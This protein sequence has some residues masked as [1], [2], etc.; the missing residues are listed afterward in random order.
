[1][2]SPIIQS[3]HDGHLLMSKRDSTSSRRQRLAATALMMC[4]MSDFAK[5]LVIS[6]LRETHSG[7]SPMPN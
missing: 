4:E 7:A 1:M 5:A 2:I 3:G 6:N